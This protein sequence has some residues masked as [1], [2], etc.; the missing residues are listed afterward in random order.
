MPFLENADLLREIFSLP[1]ME[2]SRGT[3]ATTRS[4]KARDPPSND[5]ENI[6]GSSV[7]GSSRGK[8]GSCIRAG[9]RKNNEIPSRDHDDGSRNDRVDE[10]TD[11]RSFFWRTGHSS[12]DACIVSDTLERVSRM[13]EQFSAFSFSTVVPHGYRSIPLFHSSSALLQKADL[14]RNGPTLKT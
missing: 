8:G 12:R 5:L 4:S 2:R 3:G 14:K 11:R 9:S 13:G 1:S 10:G 7:G 6:P